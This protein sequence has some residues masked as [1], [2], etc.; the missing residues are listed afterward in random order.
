MLRWCKCKSNF[1]I[2]PLGLGVALAAAC[3]RPKA[4]HPDG[5]LP[6]FHFDTSFSISFARKPNVDFQLAGSLWGGPKDARAAAHENETASGSKYFLTTAGH[7][8]PIFHC[9]PPKPPT[10]GEVRQKGQ[11]PE[12][13]GLPL[14]MNPNTPQRAG[15]TDRETNS[16]RSSQTEAALTKGLAAMM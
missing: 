1:A 9:Q 7:G 16:Q 3:P 12:L 13:L 5:D 14:K 6:A 4:A 15:A 10:R 11:R 8:T 2:Q